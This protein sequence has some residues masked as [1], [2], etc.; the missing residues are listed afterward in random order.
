V[1]PRD[2][3]LNQFKHIETEEVPYVLR[4][5]PENEDGL[6]LHYGKGWRDKIKTYINRPF[7]IDTTGQRSFGDGYDI[8]HF[9]AIWNMKTGVP[10]HER[11]A[12]PSP[13]FKG[14]EF[15]A[16][17]TFLEPLERGKAKDKGF[18]SMRE[19]S[20]SAQMIVMNWGIF[21]QTWRI[22]GYENA[23]CDMIEETDFFEELVGKL[24][25]LY[26]GFVRYCADFP[27]D[28][29]FVGDDW[30]VQR[31]LVMSAGHWRR[32]F[33]PAW[34]KVYEEIHKQGKYIVSHCC[35]GVAEIIPDIIEIKMDM[36]ESVQP[37]A[38]GMNPYHLKE[39][40]GDALGFHG[41]LGNQSTIQFG[42]PEEIRTE[43]RRLK[44]EMSKNGGYVLAAAK[45]VQ[46]G[47]PI[48][49]LIAIFEE[50]AG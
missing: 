8:D 4:L 19:Y 27:A 47:V 15:P 37:E 49:N 50:F 7:A 30:G 26:I 35:G 22:R 38:V 42:T 16:L 44:T 12:L 46:A 9:G 23:L 36:L 48:E 21:E 10:H 43:I 20:H 39:K 45:S 33:K 13:S 28:A 18:E 5:E 11:V 41:G 34:K 25:E 2:I 6:D 14:Y 1:E 32:F 40:Y 29:I 24:T 17:D 31:G 3:V